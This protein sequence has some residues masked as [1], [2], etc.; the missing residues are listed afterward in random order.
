MSRITES[1]NM[2]NSFI[3]TILAVVV[4]CIGLA[5]VVGL[6]ALGWAGRA[7]SSQFR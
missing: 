6:G 4:V 7:F 2:L 3:R 5:I 1:V